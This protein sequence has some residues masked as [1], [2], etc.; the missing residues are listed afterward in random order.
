MNHEDKKMPTW[1][2]WLFFG[3][4]GGVGAVSLISFALFHVYMP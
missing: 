1:Y 4:L 3:S 2:K